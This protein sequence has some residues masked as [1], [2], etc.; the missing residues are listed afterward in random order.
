MKRFIQT[1]LLVVLSL[2]FC[3]A[4]APKWIDKAKRSVFS[5]ITYGKDGQTLNSG[6]GFFVTE[7]G[8]GVSD[9]ELFKDAA[10]AEIITS[11]GK[12]MPIESILGVNSIYDVIKFKVAITDKK[13]P[14]LAIA[15][16]PA[17]V[18]ATIYM[19]PYSTQKERNYTSGTVKEVATIDADYHYYTLNLALTDKQASCPVMNA[20]GEVIGLT[21]LASPSDDAIGRA[22]CRA[23]V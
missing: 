14:A 21:Q 13:V 6:N 1:L 11:D 15:S 19:L 3:M 17:E 9:Y 7:S 8:V 18:D 10:S 22:S 5:I 23:R 4:Q 12:R 20:N 2:Q 16:Q